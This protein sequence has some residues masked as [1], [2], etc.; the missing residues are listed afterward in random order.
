MAHGNRKREASED[1]RRS[2]CSVQVDLREYLEKEA[3]GLL[4]TDAPVLTIIRVLDD[5]ALTCREKSQGRR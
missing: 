2:R 4:S 5:L 1:V 3:Q